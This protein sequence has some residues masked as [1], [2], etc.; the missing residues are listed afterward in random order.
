LA[1]AGTHDPTDR[2]AAQPR[3]ASLESAVITIDSSGT[4][5]FA[6]E[7][8][9][10]AF[11]YSPSEIVGQRITRLIPE[12]Y[13]H[14]HEAVFDNGL[15]TAPPWLSSNRLEVP[16]LRRDGSEF[17]VEI[18]MGECEIG[19]ARFFTGTLRDVEE[20]R[21]SIDRVHA[22]EQYY[23]QLFESSVA[24][25]YRVGF[26]G[27]IHDVNEAMARI[28]GYR[29]D[30][31][32][33]QRAQSV[34]FDVTAREDWMGRLLE[35]GSLTNFVLELRR[36][37]GS[38]VWTLENCS[39]V[40]DALT[41]ER[42]VLGTAI[43]ITERKELEERLERMAYRD[44]LT[45]LP[46]RRMLQAMVENAIA[47]ASRDGGRVAFLYID[48]VRFKR[49]NDVLGHTA[50]D[51]VLREV[52]RR[53]GS[54]VRATDTLARVGGDEFALLVVSA[55]DIEAAKA[56][57][58][59]IR[60]CL[61]RPFVVEG[62]SFHL[63]ARIGVAMYP[64]H[65]V[66]FDELLSHADLALYQPGM[67]D[68]EIAVYR[69]V[70]LRHSRA[71]L[72][73]EERFRDALARQEFELYYQP[74]FKLPE[75][76]PIGVEALTRWRQDDGRV[77]GAD[78]FISIAEQTGLIRQLDRWALYTA[79]RQMRRWLAAESPTPRWIA[80][81][82]T[83]SAF[84]DSEFPE[85]VSTV[86]EE[87]GVP[88]TRVALEV[89]ER[90]TMR[91]PARAL[92]VLTRLRDLGLR[93][94]V[95]DFGRGQSS[96]AYLKDFPVDALK[97]DR[98]F[99]GRVGQDSTHERLVEGIVALCNQLGIQLIAE[100]VESA[101]Q[102]EWLETHGCGFA[103]G[104]HLVHPVPAGLVPQVF[105]GRSYDASAPLVAFADDSTN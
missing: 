55:K 8:I 22:S 60:E 101:R 72:M 33:G 81:N 14:L 46:N 94:V 85:L 104:Y 88:G 37:D 51:Q 11:G 3:P 93:I 78:Q 57:G 96:L 47:R 48:L 105:G 71:D 92:Q 5:V 91:D 29:R 67:G 23:R 32:V 77:V 98:S 90:L 12:R 39:I 2:D 102:L 34:Y 38:R 52:A 76:E 100:G 64:D 99:V 1:V 6:S 84:D 24:G 73:L 19:G 69:P 70:D 9:E 79:V 42:A 28:L 10:A 26:D 87:E 53:F 56:P 89:T 103:Q 68:G 62:E 74:I 43:D 18:S 27:V 83:P 20:E 16:A 97:I 58:L 80:L 21:R 17:T 35:Q 82:L 36:K 54:Q 40:E 30:E 41:G 66:S 49:I 61:A 86:L 25:V 59:K 13:R 31:L 45:G 63:D 44:P 50:G 7:A 95:D 65:A 15:S 75:R 4:I